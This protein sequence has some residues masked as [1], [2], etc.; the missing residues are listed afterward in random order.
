MNKKSN[1]H[2]RKVA[3]IKIIKIVRGKKIVL[4]SKALQ[5]K[6]LQR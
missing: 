6:N 2:N 4:R 1:Q 5:Y 3:D